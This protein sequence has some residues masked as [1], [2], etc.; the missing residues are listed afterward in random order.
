MY[1]MTH[2][3]ACHDDWTS[4]LQLCLN[5]CNWY[6]FLQEYPQIYQM[7]Q[8]L[9]P[10][11]LQYYY[12][13]QS[14]LQHYPTTPWNCVVSDTNVYLNDLENVWK[15][16][17][18]MRSFSNY[19]LG[20]PW[21]IHEELDGLK[22][23]QDLEVSSNARRAAK[24]IETMLKFFRHRVVTQKKHAHNLILQVRYQEDPDDIILKSV[25]QFQYQFQG[26]VNTAIFTNDVVLKN[27]AMSHGIRVF[28][29][30]E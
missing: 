18:D 6:N 15:I 27:K 12:H 29:F 2:Y 14:S 9:S 22:R 19:F 7:L 10:M 3:Y 13:Q 11:L 17:L 28:E 16:V 25:E 4:I 1:S 20:I 30:F 26:T 21:K 23:S 5:A 24:S 8:E